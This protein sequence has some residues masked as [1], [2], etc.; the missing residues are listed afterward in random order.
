MNFFGTIRPRNIGLIFI[1]PLIVLAGYFFWTKE[2]FVLTQTGSSWV[3]AWSFTDIYDQGKSTIKLDTATTGKNTRF[4]YTLKSGYQ[5]PYVGLNFLM[6]KDSLPD[7]KRYD[8]VRIKIRATL[9][10]RLPI[11]IG[12]WQDKNTKPNGIRFMEY[13]LPVNK[14]WNTVDIDFSKFRTPEWWLIT[15]DVKEKELS[16]PDFSKMRF[17]NVQSCQI[18]GNDKEDV[19][20]I[21]ELSLRVDMTYFYLISAFLTILYYSTLLFLVFGKKGKQSVVFSYVKTEAVSHSVK[22]EETV[23]AFITSHY[24][25]Q[26][27]SIL[28]IQNGTGISEAK[29]SAIIKNK[30]GLTFKQFLNKLRLTESKRLLLE[31]DLQISEIAYK[32]GYSN[33]SHFNRIFKEVESCTPNDFRRSISSK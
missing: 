24:E 27:L 22:E 9:G 13:I 15:N 29:I 25:Q 6:N 2:P 18:L 33:V 20:E 26:N 23:F 30:S 17:L 8:Y 4:V 28:D 32:V 12:L 1:W 11:V 7:L 31:T 21:E 16:D 3:D 14:E 5:Y 10:S 19:I